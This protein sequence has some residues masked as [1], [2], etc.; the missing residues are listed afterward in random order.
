MDQ[1]GQA[2]GEDDP[3]LLSPFSLEP[4]AAGAEPAGL[5]SG[6][7]MAAADV[8]QANRELVADQLAT[9]TGED[10]RT[11]SETCPLL[12]VFAGGEPSDKAVVWQYAPADRRAVASGG[13][14]EAAGGRE[15]DPEPRGEG[16]VSDKTGWE[17][18]GQQFRD[19]HW[20]S[21]DPVPSPGLGQRKYLCAG[22]PKGGYSVR[23]L[24][25]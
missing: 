23:P 15:I 4:S 19:S 16:G 22:V 10:G 7:F 3:P 5:Q 24:E 20:H 6:E 13:I 17:G 9:T 25:L 11:A 1:G 2:G 21:R 8:A 18:R 14:A 12:L